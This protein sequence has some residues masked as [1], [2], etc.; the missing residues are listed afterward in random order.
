MLRTLEDIDAIA[1]DWRALER[2]CADPLVYFQSFD[3]CRNWVAEF[4]RS[5]KHRP[6]VVTLW[7]GDLLIAVWP[8]MIV[9]MAG[10]QRLETLGA[11]HS[12]YCG[13]LVRPDVLPVSEMS[14]Y[15]RDEIR[16]AGCDVTISRAVPEGSV[17][18]QILA[19]KPEV[20]GSANMASMLDLSHFESSEH[21]TS[22]L[23]KLQ[24]RNRNRRRNHLARLGEL[25]FE[26]LWPGDAQFR[27]LV[28]LCAEM[29]RRWIAETGRVSVGFSMPGY[30]DFL[31]NLEGDRDSLSGACLSVLRAGDRVV[32]LELGMLRN[33][34]YYAYIGG[35]DWALRDLSPG[36]V[37]MDLTVGWLIDNGIKAYDLLINPADYKASWTNTAIA[38]TARAEALS[39][40]GR[41]YACAWL[42]RLRPALKRLHGQWPVMVE[43]AGHVLRP[44]VCLLL[45]V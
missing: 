4:G 12:Q 37:Q 42:P 31:A 39:W 29:K 17:L 14:R 11:P 7:D 38:V 27:K 32:A 22:Q 26:V 16:A 35:F 19:D 2:L 3:W 15:L 30:E 33:G 34:H 9:D 5:G 36:K 23:G 13:V 25:H 28:R 20:E 8:R 18:A 45:Y 6:Y 41:L 24:K 44:G 40:K 43:R 21:Y 1:C 10:I